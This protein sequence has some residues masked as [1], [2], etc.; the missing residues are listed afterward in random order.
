MLV[1]ENMGDIVLIL[2]PLSDLMQYRRRPALVVAE[3]KK[4]HNNINVNPISNTIK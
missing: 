3:P 2:L 1:G 4:N